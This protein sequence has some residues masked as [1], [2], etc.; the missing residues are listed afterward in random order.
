MKLS[1]T[2]QDKPAKLKLSD[3]S[4]VK[5]QEPSFGEQLYGGA[6]G[7]GTGILG[8]VGDIESMVTLPSQDPK[9]RGYETTF[10]TSENVKT[11]FQKLGLPAPAPGTEASVRLGELAPAIAGGAKLAQVL[12]GYGVGKISDLASTLLGRKTAALATFCS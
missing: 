1:E 3:V 4:N 8:S 10:P 2:T 6:Y 11:G 5:K 9:L 7:L 12:G